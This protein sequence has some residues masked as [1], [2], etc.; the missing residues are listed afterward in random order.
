MPDEIDDLAEGPPAK[1]KLPIILGVLTLLVVGVGIAFATGMIGG[2]EP[3]EEENLGPEIR[4]YT[5]SKRAV[6]PLGLFTINLRGSGGG[7]VLRMEMALE[8]TPDALSTVTARDAQI[9]DAVITLV[10]DY[11]YADL[12]G[13][14]GKTR[15]RDELLGRVNALLPD[16]SRVERIYFT[17]F[18]V[19]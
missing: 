7:R 18:Y 17:Q 12:E 6:Y 10:S 5:D 15:L 4:T 19:Q 8:T 3:E 13:V 2:G 9:R 11:A 1:S 14:D 16:G